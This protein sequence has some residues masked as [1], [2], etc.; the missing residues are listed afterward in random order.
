M[1]LLS[2][3]L[4][5]LPLA[6]A[7]AGGA[8][9]DFRITITGT[10][11]FNGIGT[12][13]LGTVGV[14]ESATL[15]FL[16]N[17]EDF[18]NSPNFPTRGYFIDESSWNLQFDSGSLDLENPYSGFGAMFVIRNN[19]PA[20]DGFLVSDNVDTPMGVPLDQ[21]GVFGQF[22]HS[23]LV[24]YPGSFL[25]SLNIGGAVGTYDFTGL[26]VFNWTIDDG[27]FNP[28][29]IEFA[30]LKIERVNFKADV[31]EISLAAGGQQIMTLNAGEANANSNYWV[32]G[33]VTGTTP[34][35]DFG[36]G[37]NLPLNFDPYFRLTLFQ[38]GLSNFG[39]F[40][41]NL[42]ACGRATATLTVPAGLDPTLAGAVLNHAYVAAEI[43]GVTD[44]TSEAISL[45]LVP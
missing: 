36:P 29:G 35:I 27:P 7:P 30:E 40:K 28:L 31:S 39:M 45:T 4:C 42:D 24:T 6:A 20:V 38:V 16:V 41:G 9:T 34:G 15:T 17:S 22:E 8:G 23:F 3:A 32:F 13:F 19:D 11:E 44:Y 25:G 26:S 43:F 2:L 10:V 37:L 1:S 12:G 14:N 5:V 18:I 33:S 21:P